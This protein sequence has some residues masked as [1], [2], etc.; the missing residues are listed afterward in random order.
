MGL[1][2]E[3]VD[4]LGMLAVGSAREGGEMDEMELTGEGVGHAAPITG[5]LLERRKSGV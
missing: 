5:V 1:L 3:V 2:D 4:G